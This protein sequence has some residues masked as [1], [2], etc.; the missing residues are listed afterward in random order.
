MV[1]FMFGAQEVVQPC[2]CKNSRTISKYILYMNASLLFSLPVLKSLSFLLSLKI[3]S[4]LH[5]S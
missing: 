5:L 4:R 2:N 1:S 3:L